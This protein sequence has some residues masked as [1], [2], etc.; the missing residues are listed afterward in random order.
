MMYREFPNVKRSIIKNLVYEHVL[1]QVLSS[2]P[3]TAIA[4]DILT[5]LNQEVK[6]TIQ[7]FISPLIVE[8]KNRL[9]SFSITKATQN[10]NPFGILPALMHILSKYESLI[11]GNP[12]PQA[13]DSQPEPSQDASHSSS[14]KKEKGKERKRKEQK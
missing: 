11:A 10:T 9:P 5:S 14:R 13:H 7:V 4:D 8:L 1:D 2:N 6:D 12:M 3:V